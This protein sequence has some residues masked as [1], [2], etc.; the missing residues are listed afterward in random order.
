MMIKEASNIDSMWKPV[1]ELRLID[2][3]ISEL[4]YSK[5]YIEK[6]RLLET[7]LSHGS[8]MILR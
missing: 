4:G 1:S 5:K 3:D 2:K 8:N 7:K 6:N